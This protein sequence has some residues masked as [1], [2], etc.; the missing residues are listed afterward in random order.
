[1]LKS[2]L[3][4]SNDSII[5][6]LA[7]SDGSLL[8]IDCSPATKAPRIVSATVLDDATEITESELHART[9]VTPRQNLTDEE[10]AICQRR[11]TLISPVLTCLQDDG[12][13]NRSIALIAERNG[14]SKRTIR[15]YLYLYLAYNTK[16]I[17]APKEIKMKELTDDEKNFRWALNKYYYTRFGKTLSETFTM[18]IKERYCDGSGKVLPCHPTLHQFKYFYRTHRSLQ[19]ALISR[20]GIKDYQ[21]NHRPL[22]GGSV[23][24]FAPCVG[25][26]MLDATICDIYL[27]DDFGNVVGR[28]VLTACID[29]YSGLC[30]G[31]SLGWEGGMYSL[32]SMFLN[33]VS[34]K[35]EMCRKMGITIS[36]DDWACM[37]LP[38]ILV[39]DKG[40]EYVSQNFTQ[41][42]E[43]G[44]MI[45][46]L[47]SFRP[48][49]K[50]MVE[51]FFDLIQNDYKH[52]LKGKG[53]IDI[54]YQERGGH[55]YR[56]DACLTLSD[57]ERVVVHSIIYHNTKRIRKSF[58]L[59]EN[60]LAEGV[61][62][63]ANTIWNYGKHQAGANLIKVSAE[64]LMLVLLPRTVG[65]FARNGLIANHLRYHCE[66]FVENYLAGGSAIVAYN[67]EDVSYIYLVEQGY[68]MFSLIDSRFI[69]KSL[70]EVVEL[71]RQQKE[72]NAKCAEE[73]LQGKVDL[74][75][76]IEVIAA[77]K[78]PAVNTN[79]KNIGNTRRI[80]ESLTHKDFI[81]EV[82]NG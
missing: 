61:L 3:Y 17:L 41:L 23:Q 39:T 49:L 75:R 76:H 24:Q 42:S 62:P 69:S 67:P 43:L 10:Q 37:D 44:C 12:G 33:V 60:M 29:A 77:A 64:K 52:L 19:T 82:S 36:D 15:N 31:Y 26:G 16:A 11:Y 66:G 1:M 63:Y 8:V 7:E 4:A 81:K 22:L 27:K 28:P 57:F 25:T 50:S 14:L 34:D 21:M 13:R 18:L 53:V 58:P 70:Y 71:K 35:V 32:R 6:V 20:N 74:V 38:A 54:D 73:S 9:G 65:N 5:R 48:E 46:N 59:T 51:K 72:I 79:L 30:C 56:Q 40:K 47:P 55:D 78:K 45:I 80:E 2:K 68:R